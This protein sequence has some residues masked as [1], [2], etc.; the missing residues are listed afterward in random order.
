MTRLKYNSSE[1]SKYRRD[2]IGDRGWLVVELVDNKLLCCMAFTDY[3]L[4]L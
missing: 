4:Y 1:D 2:Y 3:Q